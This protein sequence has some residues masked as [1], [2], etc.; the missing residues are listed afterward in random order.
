MGEST[1]IVYWGVI[2]IIFTPLFTNFMGCMHQNMKMVSI[3]FR[4]RQLRN[5]LK[6]YFNLLSFSGSGISYNIKKLNL[7]LRHLNG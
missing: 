4:R 7:Q 1:Q 5:F 6:R 2:K 3:D